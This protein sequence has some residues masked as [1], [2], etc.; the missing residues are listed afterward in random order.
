MIITKDNTVMNSPPIS[1]T[2]QR[3]MLSKN[4]QSSTAFMIS[5]GS[6]VYCAEPKPA[7]FIMVEITPWTMR[8][9][10]II[11]SNP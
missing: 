2:A 9:N 7:E 10:A 3:G 5:E 11:S 1:V 6:T 4:P 8:N